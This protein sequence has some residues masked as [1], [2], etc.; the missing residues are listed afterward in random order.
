M[1]HPLQ[2]DEERVLTESQVT[3]LLNGLCI[4]LGFCLPANVAEELEFNPPR[5]IDAF[6]R[7]VFNAEGLDPALADRILYDQVRRVVALTFDGVANV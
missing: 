2:A 7:A 5:T 3:N 1:E 6:T 4:D